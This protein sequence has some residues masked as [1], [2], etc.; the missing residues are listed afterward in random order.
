[1][2]HDLVGLIDEMPPVATMTRLPATLTPLL[3]LRGGFPWRIARRW[4]RGIR[5]IQIQSRPQLCVFRAQHLY[6]GTKLL[7]LGAE[8]FD[9]LLLGNNGRL[10]LREQ[11]SE[12]SLDPPIEIPLIGTA[13]FCATPERLPVDDAVDAANDF[14]ILEGRE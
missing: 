4:L 13:S 3:S 12:F 8:T 14:M 9:H 11:C 7:H 6:L 10:R 1:M 2:L 5:R